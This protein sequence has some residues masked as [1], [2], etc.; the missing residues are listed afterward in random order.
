MVTRKEHSRRVKRKRLINKVLISIG[1]LVLILLLIGDYFDN[2]NNDITINYESYECKPNV[3]NYSLTI[4]NT[5]KLRKPAFVRVTAYNRKFQDGVDTYPIVSSKRI[6][7]NLE[8]LEEREL[9]GNIKV[10][11]KAH[12]VKFSVGTIN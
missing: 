6:E 9:T 7:I 11:V 10:P 4:Q 2:Q 5:T 8:Q 3:C 1:L 12:M